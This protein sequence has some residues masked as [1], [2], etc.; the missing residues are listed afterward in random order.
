MPDVY[1]GGAA[2]HPLSGSAGIPYSIGRNFKQH[3]RCDYSAQNLKKT[4]RT[5][6]SVTEAVADVSLDVMEKEFLVIMGPSSCGKSTLLKLLA[7][8]E[9]IDG[10]ALHICDTIAARSIP[11]T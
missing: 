6:K 4:F 11:T 8:L 1:P 9:P 3:E 10:G 2:A 5:G 7:G